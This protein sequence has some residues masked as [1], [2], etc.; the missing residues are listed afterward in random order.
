LFVPDHHLPVAG[1]Q[2]FSDVGIPCVLVMENYA[3]SRKRV[4]RCAARDESERA[5]ER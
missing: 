4:G 3:R 5:R 1:V 2:I